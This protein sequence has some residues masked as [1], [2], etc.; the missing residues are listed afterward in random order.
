MEAVSSK[1]KPSF[2]ISPLKRSTKRSEGKKMKHPETMLR[3]LGEKCTI[4]Q[5]VT[6]GNV[7]EKGKI[8]PEKI[9]WYMRKTKST[10]TVPKV[11]F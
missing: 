10:P 4:K 7:S 1:A 9:F 3:G 11:T 8:K 2:I 5:K 6:W